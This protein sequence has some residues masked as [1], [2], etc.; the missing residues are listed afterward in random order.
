V[1]VGAAVS[2]VI[3]ELIL[4]LAVY[5]MFHARQAIE[6]CSTAAPV[7]LRINSDGSVDFRGQHLRNEAEVSGKFASLGQQASQPNIY[8]VPDKHVNYV[9]VATVLQAAQQTGVH[10][11]GFTGIEQPERR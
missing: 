3:T 11:L 7:A 2:V 4:G 9:H 8:I 5:A 6:A 10:C 1:R